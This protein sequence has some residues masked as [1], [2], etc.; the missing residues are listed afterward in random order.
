[1]PSKSKRSHQE[2]CLQ[3]CAICYNESGKKCDRR[4]SAAEEAAIQQFVCTGYSCGDP[5]FPWGICR[6]CCFILSDWIS[7]KA[8]PRPL[9]VCDDYDSQIPR[10]TRSLTSCTCRICRLAKL[11]GLQWKAFVK[12]CKKKDTS[13]TSFSRGSGVKLC[14]NCF[15]RIYRGSNHS[16]TNCQSK[17][18]K[19]D[20][21]ENEAGLD[22]LE[23]VARNTIENLASNSGDNSCFFKSVNGGRP[24]Q[25]TLGKPKGNREQQPVLGLDD[26]LVLQSE[27][28][29][30]DRYTFNIDHK[31]CTDMT[32]LYYFR[33]L[34]SVLK[35]L[36]LKYG[37]KAVE[38]HIRKALVE[39]KDIFGDY[40]K[41]ESV[42]FQNSQGEEFEQTMVYCHDVDSFIEDVA[43]LRNK[44][45]QDL[46]DKVG[47]DCGQGQLLMTLTMYDPGDL[48]PGKEQV[49]NTRKSG[50]GH[51][52]RFKEIGVKKVMILACAPKV[53]ENVFNTQVFIEKVGLHR[54]PYTF[55]GDL[56]LLNIVAGIMSGSAKHPCVY[57]DVE[58]VKGVWGKQGKLRTF[59]TITEQYECWQRAGGRADKAKL[60]K[61]CIGKPLLQAPDDDPDIMLLVR[62]PPP[63]LHCKLAVN[64]FLT[65]LGKVW[66]PLFDWISSLSLVFEP[67][68][69][70]TLEGNGCTKILKNLHSL[71][72]VLPSEFLPFLHCLENFRDTLD[73]CFGYTLDPFYKDV[74]TRFRSSFNHL[75]DQFGCSETNKLHIIFNHVADFIEE[76]GKP[77]GEFSEQ[78]LES[79]HS[80]FAK[81]WAR[82]KVKQLKSKFFAP[83]YLR[84]VLTFNSLH[85]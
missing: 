56:K 31:N 50:I 41:S 8:N 4:V 5:N 49:R 35:N 64:H 20:N 75:R 58:R 30:S 17:R 13:K 80:E 34:I 27:A 77:L 19:I 63:A 66:P 25:V 39:R 36:R 42:T 3:V 47:L 68:H 59:R 60:F 62:M 11:N 46:C 18:F 69:G 9:P 29:L 26:I 84:A 48:L 22:T 43:A 32:L 51:S 67:Y 12:R 16:L 14:S 79:A 65:E 2:N 52:V 53:P 72:E 21:L 45:V 24:A 37:F 54:L 6:N 40:F 70:T 23:K 82:Y 1:M 81:I 15:S 33:Q 38:P 44:T 74:I 55:T 73:S 71:E 57:C 85:I 78:E 10:N 61:N 28:N 76:V 83:N 7:E